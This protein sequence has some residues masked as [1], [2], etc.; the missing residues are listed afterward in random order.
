MERERERERE[1][2][3]VCVLNKIDYRQ[4]GIPVKVKNPEADINLKWFYV[5]E[6]TR[7]I[8]NFSLY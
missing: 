3:C 4:G 1:R 8:Y 2:V 6:S 5:A 7:L